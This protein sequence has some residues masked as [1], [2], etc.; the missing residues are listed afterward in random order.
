MTTAPGGEDASWRDVLAEI[1]EA[2]QQLSAVGPGDVRV[3]LEHAERIA[4]QL[5][6]PDV[7]LDLG[8]GAGIPGLAL[9]GLWPDSRWLL[10]DAAL[11]RTRL[12]DEA[13]LRL[14]WSGRVQIVHGRAEDLGRDPRWRGQ[15]DLVTARLFGPPAA[16]AE[17][18]RPF[19]RAGGILA[20]TEPPDADAHRWPAEGLALLGLEA[21][22][23]APGLQRLRAVGTVPD[24]FPRKA[25]VPVK[26][27]L[28]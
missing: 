6:A 18:G 11:R 14:G 7:A 3:H 1:W 27:P 25:G 19:L 13:V 28:F 2:G 20:V 15:L 5:D 17:C 23:P 26:R 4:D 22:D 21:L 10:L 8:S 24:R 16:A 12:L 9:A